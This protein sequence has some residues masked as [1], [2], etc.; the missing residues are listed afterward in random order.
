MLDRDYVNAVALCCASATNIN[1]TEP[2]TG[3]FFMQKICANDV[4]RIIEMPDGSTMTP[5]DAV[6]WLEDQDAKKQEEKAEEV[7]HE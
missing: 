6:K 5:L 2:N 7:E 4:G 1:F 3:T